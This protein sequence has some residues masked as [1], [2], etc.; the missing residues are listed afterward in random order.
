MMRSGILAWNNRKPN[1]PQIFILRAGLQVPAAGV[2]RRLA[3]WPPSASLFPVAE[4][5]GEG[6]TPYGASNSLAIVLHTPVETHYIDISY[7]VL[8]VTEIRL[9]LHCIAFLLSCKHVYPPN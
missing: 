7:V 3:M 9:E 2:L 6:S 4:P 8:I 5:R 1:A